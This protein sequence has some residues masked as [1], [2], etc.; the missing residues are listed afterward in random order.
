M[1]LAKR[2]PGVFLSFK[3]LQSVLEIVVAWGVRGASWLGVPFCVLSSMVVSCWAALK[4]S[5]VPLPLVMSC[6]YLW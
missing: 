1:Q 6:G 5:D 2:M 4:G 3:E